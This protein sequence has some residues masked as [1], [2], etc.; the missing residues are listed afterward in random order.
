MNPRMTAG[1][2]VVM[3]AALAAAGVPAMVGAQTPASDG[4]VTYSRDIAPILQR[5]CES[6]HRAGG[7]G[8]MSLQTYDEVRP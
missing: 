1:L 8:P 4:A 7:A 6:C 2:G 5:S 3:L